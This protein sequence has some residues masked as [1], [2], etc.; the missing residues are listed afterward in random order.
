[1]HQSGIATLDWV[2]FATYSE[3][4]WTVGGLPF[5]SSVSIKFKLRCSN[6][7]F[8]IQRTCSNASLM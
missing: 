1:M 2:N 5:V 3:S 7:I 4:F 6:E 8:R